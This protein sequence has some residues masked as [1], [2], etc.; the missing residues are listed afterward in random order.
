MPDADKHAT[1][2]IATLLSNE[3]KH[4]DKAIKYAQ[5]FIA[6]KGPPDDLVLATMA[7][8]YYYLNDF[9]NAESDGT[10]AIA[11]TPA[12]KAPNRGAWRSCSAARSSKRRT[13]TP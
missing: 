10:K 12:G 9:A 5:A 8:S 7:Q 6:L 3:A 13:P 1:L 11:A 4:Y 2:R